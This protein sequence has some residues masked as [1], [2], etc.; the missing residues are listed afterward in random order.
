MASKLLTA[1]LVSVMLISLF[2]S[3]AA[4]KGFQQRVATGGSY[5]VHRYQYDLMDRTP[6]KPQASTSPSTGET[7]PGFASGGREFYRQSFS[8][9]SAPKN[10]ELNVENKLGTKWPVSFFNRNTGKGRENSRIFK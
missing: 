5:A 8:V 1:V 10:M 9:A 2:A 3:G 4:A 7:K 6:P